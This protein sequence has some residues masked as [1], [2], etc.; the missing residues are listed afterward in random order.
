MSFPE[1]GYLEGVKVKDKAILKCYSVAF[2]YPNT[3]RQVINGISIFVSLASRVAVIG[4]NGSFQ[5]AW[6]LLVWVEALESAF[7]CLFG[8]GKEKLSVY[9]T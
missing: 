7:G 2:T 5:L 9:L 6:Y 4:P 3:T 1:P 8:G